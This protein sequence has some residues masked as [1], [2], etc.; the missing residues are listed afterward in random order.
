MI[1]NLSLH[2]GIIH[3]YMRYLRDVKLQNNR[4]LF[5][6]NLSR[7][8]QILGMEISKQLAYVPIS[9]TTPLG[10]AEQK[11][12]E[13]SPVIIS[14]LRAGL[15]LHEGLLCVFPEAESG[16]IAAYRKHVNNGEDFVIDAKYT[17]C[18]NLEG[19][20]LILND[21]MLATGQSFLT[22]IEVLKAFGKPKHIHLAAVI[23]SEEGV[24]NI[25]SAMA[26][27]FDLWI[28]AIDPFLNSSKYIVPG[29]GDAG[30]LAFGEKSQR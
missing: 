3:E 26:E 5:R 10:E 20:T 6:L 28:G 29:L 9:V 24:R 17:A 13:D 30:D 22:A 8:G 18:P 7:V 16:Y 4:E 2:N 21:P 11:K 27:P 1:N 25:E 19:R 15:P 12:L 23:G 14:V